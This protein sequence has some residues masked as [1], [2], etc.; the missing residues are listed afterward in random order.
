[1]AKNAKKIGRKLE[2][3]ENFWSFW[4]GLGVFLERIGEAEIGRLI[5][6]YGLYCLNMVVYTVIL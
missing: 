2:F 3:L 6:I 4:S 5:D 1:M